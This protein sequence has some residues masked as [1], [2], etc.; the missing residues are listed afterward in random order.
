MYIKIRM[1]KSAAMHAHPLSRE[2]FSLKIDVR[3]QTLW[4]FILE[5]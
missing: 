3:D 2:Q 4:N 5:L 1:P